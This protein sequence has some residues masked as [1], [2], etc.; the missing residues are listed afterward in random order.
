MAHT[1]GARRL[2]VQYRS[3][4]PATAVKPAIAICAEEGTWLNID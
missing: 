4:Q 1:S 3:L 2:P